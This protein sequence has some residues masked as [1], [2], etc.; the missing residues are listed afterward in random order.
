MAAT[1][2][3]L[4][5]AALF[6]DLGHLPF[7]HDVE[8]ALQDY[9]AIMH[10]KGT[11]LLEPLAQIASDSAPH[12]EIGHKLAELAFHSLTQDTQPAV[13]AAFE[14]A[15]SILQYGESELRSQRKTSSNASPMASFVGTDRDRAQLDPRRRSWQLPHRNH[16]GGVE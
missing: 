6:H 4:R 15:T 13:R 3:G 10:S 8:Y 14:M 1:E 9:A 11:P 7:S 2:A 5:L 12:E 16:A